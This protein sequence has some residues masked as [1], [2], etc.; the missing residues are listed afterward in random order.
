MYYKVNT[1]IPGSSIVSRGIDHDYKQHVITK[2][3]DLGN[4]KYGTNK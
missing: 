2:I 3:S 1:I 4:I